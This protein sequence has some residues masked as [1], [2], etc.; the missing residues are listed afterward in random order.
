MI[1]QIWFQF[2]NPGANAAESLARHLTTFQTHAMGPGASALDEVVEELAASVLADNSTPFPRAYSVYDFDADDEIGARLRP[3][4]RF[5]TAS[6]RTDYPGFS[7]SQPFPGG[8]N[9]WR[10]L[11]GASLAD[12]DL[13]REPA[14]A[15]EARSLRVTAAFRS[16]GDSVGRRPTAAF[17]AAL[18]N[19]HS[20]TPFDAN[21]FEHAAAKAG[22]DIGALLGDWI[23][24]AGLPG[25]VTSRAQ[26]SEVVDSEGN[27][28]F[29]TRVHVRNGE[30]V[31]GLVR[32]STRDY[33]PTVT[34]PIH[35][36]GNTTKEVGIVTDEAPVQLW[37][38]PYLALN[39]ALVWIDIDNKAGSPNPPDRE[40]LTGA[41][42]SAWMPHVEG[43][44][45]D[46]LDPGFAVER[47]NGLR[48]VADP[49]RQAFGGIESD[50]DEGLPVNSQTPGEWSR[51][52][53]PTSWGRYRHTVAG[54][55]A[56]DG[57]Q[58]ALFTANLPTSGRWRLDFHLPDPQPPGW[59]WPPGSRSYA[60]LGTFDMKLLA[61][62]ETTPLL[63]DGA[64]A[65]TG[66]N[67]VAEFDLAATQ[68]R[69]EISSRTDGEMV[70]ADAIRWVP[71]GG[72]HT[73][74]P[75]APGDT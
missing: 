31:P 25:F 55:L 70:I 53:Y 18:R 52:T 57:S 10:R 17:L 6:T 7:T 42:P 44:V 46:D 63:F 1:L 26:V 41:R 21:D 8:P 24:E 60:A 34:D 36:P 71:L 40:L 28:R 75:D 67:K 73:I 23:S 2:A 64:V 19:R 5:L 65:K 45:V 61:D 15:V 33:P 12:L 68:V 9:T 11:L 72:T 20:G 48:E 74:G 59:G 3:I 27:V 38:E 69:L 58:V 56:G 37:L 51:V 54:A 32:L 35:I 43:I 4:V 66:W 16:I 29:E 39:R 13:R 14:A 22:L 30:P 47:R 49:S 50:L 62:G